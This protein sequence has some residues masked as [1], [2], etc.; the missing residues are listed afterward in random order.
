M[1]IPEVREGDKERER[2]RERER[3]MKKKD[4]IDMRKSGER[5]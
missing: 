2:E 4:V 1:K 5:G 3:E